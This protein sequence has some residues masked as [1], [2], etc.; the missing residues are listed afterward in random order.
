[1]DDVYKKEIEAYVDGELAPE[2]R[3]RVEETMK[4][5]PTLDDYAEKVKKQNELLIKWWENDKKNYH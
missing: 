4:S 5:F 2:K 1:M 3:D